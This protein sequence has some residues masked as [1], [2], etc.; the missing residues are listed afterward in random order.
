MITK[1]TEIT[2]EGDGISL[3]LNR[4]TVKTKLMLK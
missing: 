4:E 1:R 3:E 2:T